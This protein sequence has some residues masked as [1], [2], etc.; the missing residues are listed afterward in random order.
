MPPSQDAT[1]NV[2]PSINLAGDVSFSKK[3]K[4][5]GDAKPKSEFKDGILL[6]FS[7]LL[8]L[9]QLAEENNPIT[10]NKND[11]NNSIPTINF[12]LMIDV[13]VNIIVDANTFIG[14]FCTYN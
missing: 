8:N 6:D 5:S 12:V 1:R 4:L 14:L 3:H 10:K 2:S 13:I 9:N 7:Q 11:E